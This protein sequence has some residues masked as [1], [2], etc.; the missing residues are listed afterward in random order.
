[1]TN[2]SNN[3]TEYKRHNEAMQRRQ[4]NGFNAFLSLKKGNV[5]WFTS[6]QMRFY[7]DTNVIHLPLTIDGSIM[8]PIDPLGCKYNE[9]AHYIV[10]L[11]CCSY[12][13]DT[14]CL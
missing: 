2:V 12:I 4:I 8:V 14:V 5:T 6:A 3:T 7:Y 1:M 9:S 11:T 10:Y 13:E